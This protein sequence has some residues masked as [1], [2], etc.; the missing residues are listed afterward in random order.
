MQLQGA[1]S[2]TDYIFVDKM[3]LHS[4]CGTCGVSVVVRVTD[5][6]EDIMPLNVRTIDGIDLESL[7]FQRYDGMSK[8]PPYLV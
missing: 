7:Q 8:D 6:T 1:E 3:S 5:P 4:F 2:L